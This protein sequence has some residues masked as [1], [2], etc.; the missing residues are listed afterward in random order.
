MHDRS[1][2]AKKS[3]SNGLEIARQNSTIQAEGLKRMA[4]ETRSA[5]HG[6]PS[7]SSRGRNLETSNLLGS[8]SASKSASSKDIWKNFESV[9]EHDDMEGSPRHSA[10]R[11][12]RG[13]HPERAK[14]ESECRHDAKRAARNLHYDSDNYNISRPL[15]SEMKSSNIEEGSELIDLAHL[16][17]RITAAPDVDTTNK[18]IAALLGGTGA[19]KTTTIDFCCC[20]SMVELRSEDQYDDTVRIDVCPSEREKFLR[21]GHGESMT[22]TIDLLVS[23]V[24]PKRMKEKILFCGKISNLHYHERYSLPQCCSE[25]WLSLHRYARLK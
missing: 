13:E 12:G 16:A 22:K 25:V 9:N 2:D 1:L 21:I 7:P 23:P 24:K 10:A 17:R 11:R 14:L 8:N 20:A 18:D 4:V 19:G 6:F 3:V 15:C 5:Q